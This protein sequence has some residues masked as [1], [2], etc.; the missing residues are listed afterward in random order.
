MTLKECWDKARKMG[1]KDVRRFMR[2]MRRAGFEVQDAILSG[3]EFLD[4]PRCRR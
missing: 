4:R 1:L 2:D 3:P